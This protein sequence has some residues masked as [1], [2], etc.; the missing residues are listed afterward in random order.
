MKNSREEIE[1]EIVEFGP[2]VDVGKS[3]DGAYM[4]SMTLDEYRR[5][6]NRSNRQAVREVLGSLAVGFSRWR[7]HGLYG[8]KPADYPDFGPEWSKLLEY[9]GLDK[10][11]QELAGEEQ[12]VE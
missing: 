11:E 10:L 2:V 12:D 1:K 7:Y 6:E 9:S 4:V 3:H 5:R 8:S